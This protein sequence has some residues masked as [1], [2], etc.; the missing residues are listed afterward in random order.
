[1]PEIVHKARG[2]RTTRLYE[3][4]VVQEVDALPGQIIEQPSE[5]LGL[6]QAIQV[7]IQYVPSDYSQKQRYSFYRNIW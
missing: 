5:K 7:N 3:V 2:F 6:T 1:M 4:R